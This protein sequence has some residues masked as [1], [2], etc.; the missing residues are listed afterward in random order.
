MLSNNDVSSGGYAH[1]CIRYT[2]Y[3]VMGLH[4]PGGGRCLFLQHVQSRKPAMKTLL[5]LLTALAIS[6][7][8]LSETTYCHAAASEKQ[9]AGTAKNSFEKKCVKD[10]VGAP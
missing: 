6:A 9:L 4:D 7:P 8:V 3:I 5:P 10:A 2:V 1:T